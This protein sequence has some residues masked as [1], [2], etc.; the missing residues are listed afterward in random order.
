MTTALQPKKSEETRKRILEAALTIFRE[1]G[2]ERATMRDVAAGAGL[3]VGAA[4]YYFDS[5]DAIVTA[6]Y[7]RAQHEMQSALAD[8]LARSRNFEERLGGIIRVKLAYFQ[9]NRTLLEA[10]SSHVDPK[11]PLSPFS[12]ES[13]A[14]RD[15]DIASFARA[16]TDSKIVLPRNLQPY[17]PRLLW[18]YQMG[19][20]LFWVYDASPDQQRTHTLLDKTLKMLLLTL[21]LVKIPLLRPLHKLAAELL[22]VVYG[23]A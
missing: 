17:L 4:Y 8:L 1:R 21:K 2:F 16:V 12:E 7:E 23:R 10:L 11:H 15:Q 5:K 14:I 22:E 9:E 6:F 3:A 13:A 20:L 19:I 18:L